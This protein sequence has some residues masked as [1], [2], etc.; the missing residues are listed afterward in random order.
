M[1][2]GGILSD[3]SDGNVV[4]NNVVYNPKS[5]R[6]GD[7]RS[8]QAPDT[9]TYGNNLCARSGIGCSLVADPLFVDAANGNF[10]LQSVS[11]AAGMGAALY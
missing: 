4:K 10:N 8:W 9:T 6:D 5:P 7:I 11:P 3:H 1:N 2:V